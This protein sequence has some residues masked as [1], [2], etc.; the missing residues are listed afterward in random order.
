MQ[1]AH[2]EHPH[3]LEDRWSRWKNPLY[4]NVWCLM[5]KQEKRKLLYLQAYIF[6]MCSCV[7]YSLHTVVRKHTEK[8]ILLYICQKLISMHDFF[9]PLPFQITVKLRGSR[10]HFWHPAN[11]HQGAWKKS[12]EKDSEDTLLHTQDKVHRW[13]T[14]NVLL[15]FFFPIAGFPPQ[16][17]LCFFLT[18][19]C[20]IRR[21][22]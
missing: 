12:A 6:V 3:F 19:I 21:L 9:G 5:Y 14:V 1:V 16:I 11:L 2:P 13:K 10:E 7:F 22:F 20:D 4:C 15:P 8:H 17:I 18:W